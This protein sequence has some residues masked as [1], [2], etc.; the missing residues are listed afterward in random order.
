MSLRAGVQ[1]MIIKERNDKKKKKDWHQGGKENRDVWCRAWNRML[2]PPIVQVMWRAASMGK[3][4]WTQLGSAFPTDSL[5]QTHSRK[6]LSCESISWN[7]IVTSSVGVTM[8][9]KCR[10]ST[11]CPERL[12]RTCSGLNMTGRLTWNAPSVWTLWGLSYQPGARWF[13]WSLD[14]KN[15]GEISH[16][17]F[18]LSPVWHLF[19]YCCY[20]GSREG[21]N[22]CSPIY[23]IV[24]HIPAITEA[25]AGSQ[26]HDPCFP[27]MWHGPNN[28]SHHHCLLGVYL[29]GM[30]ETNIF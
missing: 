19:I 14:Q 8:C 6:P 11:A 24:Y 2:T 13:W 12:I 17:V 29:G 16:T 1:R 10:N 27:S 7:Q 23:W 15:P 9:C 28:M 5:K 4:W 20:L 26:H 21:E 25:I 22:E 30:F 3:R 18:S